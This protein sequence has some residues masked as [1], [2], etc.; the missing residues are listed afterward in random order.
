MIQKDYF[1]ESML[2]NLSTCFLST[3]HVEDHRV[4]RLGIYLVHFKGNLQNY[5][6]VILKT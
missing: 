6:L 4:L 2:W 3:S 5:T 1:D